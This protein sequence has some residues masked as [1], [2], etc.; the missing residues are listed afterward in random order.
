MDAAL[1]LYGAVIGLIMTAPVGPVNLLV[2]RHAVRNGFTLAFLCGL[3]SALADAL[4]ASVAAYGVSSVAH[5]LTTY[6]RPL[7]A[8]G[9]VVLVVM[10][11]RIAR[12]RTELQNA[13]AGA[14]PVAGDI[15]RKMFTAFMLTLTNPGVLFGFLA[16]FGALNGVLRLH[17]SPWRPAIA[18]AGVIAGDVLWWLF[19][20]AMVARYRRR[21]TGKA[22][23]RVNRWTGILIAAFGFVL[24]FEGVS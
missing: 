1:F 20:S 5:L 8:A 6:E 14:P 22:F 12:T 13:A 19:L 24:L 21:L 10:G 7:M 18:V 16:V 15:A 4:Y 23:A 2:I 17:E 11:V 9:G 3:A